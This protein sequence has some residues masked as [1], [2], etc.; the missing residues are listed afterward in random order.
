MTVKSEGPA[1]LIPRAPVS[2]QRL[3][4]DARSTAA[5]RQSTVEHE[6]LLL[7]SSHGLMFQGK[8]KRG[9][10]GGSWCM[11]IRRDVPANV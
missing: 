4:S 1:A 5:F 7:E 11:D 10:V 9:K 8:Y 3:L 6:A 2:F